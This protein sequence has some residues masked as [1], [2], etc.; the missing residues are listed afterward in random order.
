MNIG[1]VFVKTKAAIIGELRASNHF[2]EA[3]AIFRKNSVYSYFIVAVGIC[4][5]L[6]LWFVFPSFIVW[7]RMLPFV[8]TFILFFAFAMTMLTI[9]Q[10]M[11]ARCSKD[12][13]FFKI[14]MFVNFAFPLLLLVSLYFRPDI[15]AVLFTFVTIHTIEF[16]W[17]I[18]KYKNL[19]GYWW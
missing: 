16:I 4:A 1:Q 5:V 19:Y 17:G 7:K 13:P 2:Q 18:K 10:A 14:S 8:Q 12:E 9:N 11:F 6:A 3:Y 15:W